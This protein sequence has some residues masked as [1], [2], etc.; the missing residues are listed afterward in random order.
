MPERFIW[1]P[2]YRGRTVAEVSAELRS[3]LEHDQRSYELLLA[4]ADQREGAALA[5][6]L[7][8]EKR[9]G[10][11]DF[12]WAATEPA[13]LAGRIAAFERERERRRELIS[14]EAYRRE[15]TPQTEPSPRPWW[16]VWRR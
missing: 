10:E 12:D 3:D 5:A 8:L 4:G 2:Q 16:A 14:Y 11:F 15:S 9:W 7:P 1:H 13:E 6:V